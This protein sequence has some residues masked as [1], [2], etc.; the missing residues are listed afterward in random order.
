MTLAMDNYFVDRENTP[1]DEEGN[2]DFE[3]IEAR[4]LDMLSGHLGRLLAGE[5]VVIPQFDTIEGKKF[6]G[7]KI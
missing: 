6:P 1:R 7:K 3:V 2:Y 4:E 5:E